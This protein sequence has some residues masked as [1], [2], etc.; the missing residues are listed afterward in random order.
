MPDVLAVLGNT[1]EEPFV[2]PP[3]IAAA[4]RAN[5]PA[6]AN[7]QRYSGAYQRIRVAYVETARKRPEEFKKRL[8]FFIKKTRQ[9]K[10][11]GFGGIEKYY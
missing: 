1:L 5:E 10:Q 11:I 6:W 4:L 9:N 8:D 7:F 3:D 2:F